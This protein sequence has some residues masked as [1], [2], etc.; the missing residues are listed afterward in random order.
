MNYR[1]GRTKRVR[2]VRVSAPEPPTDCH[3]LARHRTA[4]KR[5]K[6]RTKHVLANDSAQ[7]VVVEVTTEEPKYEQRD[8][9]DRF[10]QS[11]IQ[12][13]IVKSSIQSPKDVDKQGE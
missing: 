1:S 9:Y 12:R 7:E 2:E 13:M 3:E 4:T 11:V 10:W 5:E 6:G 8:A